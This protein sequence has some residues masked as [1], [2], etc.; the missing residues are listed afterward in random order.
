M[1]KV[2]FVVSHIAAGSYELIHIL[3]QHPRIKIMRLEATYSSPTDLTPLFRKSEGDVAG[4]Y[5]GDHLL[6]NM[7]FSCK[8]LYDLCKF[9]Y[10][11][12]SPR[13]TL[14]LLWGD[15][16]FTNK[17]M[18]NN[19]YCFRLRRIYE[20]A[21]RTPGAVV[22]TWN[23]L[24]TGKGLPMIQDYL[25]LRQPIIH[26]NVFPDSAP[27]LLLPSEIE[28]SELYYEKYLYLLKKLDLRII[29]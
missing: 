10:V 15:E 3:N 20:M 19:H 26:R 23:E 2:V 24:M 13:P 14:N 16:I 29:R 1:K 8:L 6:H 7:A 11:I 27:D 4:T 28:E 18:L 12:R 17:T 25:G 9:I 21:K 22:L 5:Y